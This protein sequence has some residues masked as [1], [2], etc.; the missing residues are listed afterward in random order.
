[1]PYP[2]STVPLLKAVRLYS[3]IELAIFATLLTVWLGQ[4]GE[5]AKEVLGWTHGVGWIGL[6]GLVYAACRSR[7]LPWP[8]L[9][10]SVSPLGPMGSSLGIELALRR[11][12]G[13][14]RGP[15]PSVP[16]SLHA[17]PA[18]AEARAH[19]AGRSRKA[20]P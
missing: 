7:L 1:M 11:G 5:T 20:G 8:V 9:A 4:L 12:A 3:H 17:Q 15:S 19:G 14:D 10:A 16:R 18:I 6:C 13:P 2:R